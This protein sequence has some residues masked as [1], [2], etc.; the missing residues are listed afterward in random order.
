MLAQIPVDGRR[1][2]TGT[3]AGPSLSRQAMSIS[4]A[5]DLPGISREMINLVRFFFRTRIPSRPLQRPRPNPHSVP[6]CQIGIRLDAKSAL[7]HL[8]YPFDLS[9]G[10]RRRVACPSHD[11]KYSRRTGDLELGVHPTTDED[12]TGKQSRLVRSCHRW[13]TA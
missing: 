11:G 1:E 2:T 6:G 3:G 4:T 10:N 5:T 12:I 13:V 7:D 9:V 8:A